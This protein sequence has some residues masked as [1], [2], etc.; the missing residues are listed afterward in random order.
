MGDFVDSEK[1]LVPPEEDAGVLV[2]PKPVKPEVRAEVLVAAG[3]DTEE[4]VPLEAGKVKAELAPIP[5]AAAEDTLAVAVVTV[6]NRAEGEVPNVNGFETGALERDDARA[7]EPVVPNEK[8]GVDDEE[9]V[10]DAEDA[11]VVLFRNDKP[12]EVVELGAVEKENAGADEADGAGND[13]PGVEEVVVEEALGKE[14]PGAEAA[15]LE[16][17]MDEEN[18]EVELDEPGNENPGAEEAELEVLADNELL[19]EEADDDP[20]RPGVDPKLDPNKDGE[21]PPV[22]VADEGVEDPNMA[23]AEEPGPNMDVVA[24]AVGA[25]VDDPN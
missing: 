2:V 21:A 24:A 4:D 7:G 11:G 9:T 10:A 16:L 22:V 12:D 20:K 5:T 6:E 19:S 15:E 1:A 18:A 25:D 14:N 17:L 3:V 23:A 13:S 8:P